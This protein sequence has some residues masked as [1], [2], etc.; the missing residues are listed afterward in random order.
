MEPVINIR[1]QSFSLGSAL[2]WWQTGHNGWMKGH[3]DINL[4]AAILE[5]RRNNPNYEQLNN[6]Q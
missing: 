3:F 6:K 1:K 4:Y 5:Y 2:N